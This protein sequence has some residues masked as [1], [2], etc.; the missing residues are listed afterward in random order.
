[1][2]NF[3]SRSLLCRSNPSNSRSFFTKEVREKVGTGL[4][5]WRGLF[6]SVRPT[7]GK[8]IVNVDIATAVMYSSGSLLDLVK[9]FLGVSNVRDIS[10]NSPALNRMNAQRLKKFLRGLRVRTTTPFRDPPSWKR[11]FD[12]VLTGADDYTFDLNT[13]G[14]NISITNYYKR[15]HRYSVQCGKAI[16]ISLGKAGVVPLEVLEVKEGQFFKKSL[17][18]TAAARALKFATQRPQ[19]RTKIIEKSRAILGYADSDF[20]RQSGFI[21]DHQ[22]MSVGGRVLPVPQIR[23]GGNARAEVP[24]GGAWNV[25]GKTFYRPARVKA[26]AVVI[27]DH[28]AR[29][30]AND[31]RGFIHNFV[32]ACRQLGMSEVHLPDIDLQN[33][34]NKAIDTFGSSFAPEETPIPSFLLIILPDS[35]IDIKT[36]VKHWGDCRFGIPT[37]CIKVGKIARANNQ[38][39]NNLALKL[40]VKLRGINS[41]PA[42]NAHIMALLAKEPT[43][44]IGADVSHPSPG[45]D[46]PSVA[47]LV[48]SV[49]ENF[50]MYEASTGI[51]ESRLE[52]IEDI[53]GMI[54]KA[55]RGFFLYWKKRN[56]PCL[57][58][59]IIFFR[60]GISEGQFS[61]IG[62][63]EIN[64]IKSKEKR[65]EGQPPK[66]TYIVVV[67]KHHVRF[68]P[69]SPRDADKSGNCPPGMIID[70]EIV[71]PVDYDFFLQSHS[72][73]LG[74][75][76]PSHYTVLQDNNGFGPDNLQGI[77]Y[78]LCHV[79]ARSTRSVSIPAPVYYA[80]IVCARGRFH[81]KLI[82]DG[83]DS[84]GST[85]TGDGVTLEDHK[86][87]FRNISENMRDSMYFM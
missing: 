67:K 55:V 8:L 20:M 29:T 51:Q 46:R 48:S 49:D 60:D 73:I 43:M 50:A 86:R 23:W 84:A 11:I 83:E 87:A 27:F 18:P 63:Q 44:I 26:W 2:T 64:K 40:N 15:T 42:N 5:V 36:A 80:D 61:N 53:D 33:A 65:F 81:S 30:T 75:S 38:Y 1:M 47:G 9:E 37:Q 19:E 13:T 14:E 21:I 57:P 45:S 85:V 10:P 12:I 16:C 17:H 31:V 79:Y 22:L 25:V 7:I 76:R 24:R 59:R 66:L 28:G 54:E 39:H 72:G 68:F 78:L 52:F 77:S 82:H 4:E 41:I 58:K 32:Q 56:A 34:G 6:Q 71:N 62:E 74:T 69:N 70:S 35:A 3:H